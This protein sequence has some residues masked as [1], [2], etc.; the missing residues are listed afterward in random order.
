[1]PFWPQR[2][3]V[4][5][6]VAD[7]PTTL[8]ILN[9]LRGA[10][11]D[12]VEDVRLL[13]H[14]QDL[15]AS[16][17][18]LL[19]TEH[20]GMPFKPCQGIGMGHLCCGYR[21]LD[22]VSGCPMECSYCILQSYLANNPVMTVY[23]NLEQ[24]LSQVSEFLATRPREFF[25]IGTGELGDSLALDGLTDFARV[26]IPFFA[27]K[28]NAILELKTKTA[29]ID[30]LLDLEH[31]NRTVLAWSVNTPEII[32]SEE[33]GTASLEERFAAAQRAAAAGYGVAFHFDPMILTNRMEEE[34]AAYQSVVEQMLTAVP[35]SSIAWVSLGLLRYPPDLPS[36]T[37]RRFPETRLFTGEIVPIGGKMRYYRFIREQVYRP[38]WQRLRAKLPAH[39]IYLCMET[40]EMWS[41]IDPT[42]S[43]SCD[44]ERR[45]CPTETL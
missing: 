15:K 23:V 12:V 36:F 7:H 40:P 16:K 3:F 2:V 31:R 10:E 13:K 8:R 24:I 42:I 33:R 34:I 35:A 41:R 37:F 25:R 26:L 19:I 5:R 14:P 6:A 20:R 21:V 43:S 38:I 1:M 18:R 44:L 29:A 11:V 28:R 9:Q 32:A 27:G 4:D 30:H 17:Q 22:L 45:L 39:K